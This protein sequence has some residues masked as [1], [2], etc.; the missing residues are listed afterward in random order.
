MAILEAMYYEIP[1]VALKAPGPEYI[2]ENGQ[3][4]YICNSDD[5][6]TD[7]I[8][9][10]DKNTVGFQAK[11]RVLDKFVWEKSA[12]EIMKII[13]CIGEFTNFE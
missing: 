13:S 10:A 12:D 11:Q 1:V 5:E 3:S 7:R 6:L 8:L 2:I 9:Y 4:G